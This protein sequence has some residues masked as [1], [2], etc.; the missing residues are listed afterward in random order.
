MATQ[1]GNL[2]IAHITIGGVFPNLDNVIEYFKVLSREKRMTVSYTYSESPS[3]ASLQEITIKGE[4]NA[5]IAAQQKIVSL[6][7]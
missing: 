7:N 4:A 1:T 5:L 6:L 3:Q 2:H